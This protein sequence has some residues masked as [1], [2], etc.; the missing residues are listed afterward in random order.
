MRLY[1][2]LSCIILTFQVVPA[3]N[4]PRPLGSSA[5]S[6]KNVLRVYSG[7]P[8]TKQRW[9]EFYGVSLLNLFV[10]LRY[11]L[12][13]PVPG[14]DVWKVAVTGGTAAHPV[15]PAHATLTALQARQQSIVYLYFMGPSTLPNQF[16][17]PNYFGAAGVL[18]L[19]SDTADDRIVPLYVGKTYEPRTRYTA[20]QRDNVYAKFTALQAQSPYVLNLYYTHVEVTNDFDAKTIELLILELFNFIENYEDNLRA[21]RGETAGLVDY[22]LAPYRNYANTFGYP[23]NILAQQ[24]VNSIKCKVNTGFLRNADRFLGY[25]DTPNVDPNYAIQYIP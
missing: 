13:N 8:N 7:V 1:L 23:A 11:P 14:L 17:F 6:C 18:A 2:I 5:P 15:H 20:H 25:L 16:V 24:V 4:P 12:P 21:R 9:A 10:W 22:E 19:Q 3:C